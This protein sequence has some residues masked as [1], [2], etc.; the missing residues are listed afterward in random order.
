MI[1]YVSSLIMPTT[2]GRLYELKYKNEAESLK[3]EYPRF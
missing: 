1:R 2:K 3:C